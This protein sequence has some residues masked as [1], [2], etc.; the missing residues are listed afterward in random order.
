MSDRLVTKISNGFC[1]FAFTVLGIIIT[2]LA[3]NSVDMV[4]LEVLFALAVA[5]MIIAA[6]MP[7]FEAWGRE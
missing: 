4:P 1:I 3:S 7:L 2:M 5:A 6:F